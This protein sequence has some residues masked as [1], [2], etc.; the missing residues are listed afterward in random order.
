MFEEQECIRQS[1]P[2]APLLDAPLVEQ[3]VFILNQPKSPNREKTPF[4]VHEQD[5]SWLISYASR[6]RLI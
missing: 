2:L 1:A 3:T 6:K 5:Y 4:V